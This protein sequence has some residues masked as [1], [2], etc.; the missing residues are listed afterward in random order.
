M[1]LS[2]SYRERL[3][4]ED[5]LTIYGMSG[6]EL[7]IRIIFED[8]GKMMERKQASKDSLSSSYWAGEAIAYWQA[9]TQL[10][11]ASLLERL[12]LTEIK[13]MYSPYHEMDFGAFATEANRRYKENETIT[14]LQMARSKAKLS[15][16]KLANR[17]GL[18]LR[19]LQDYEQNRKSLSNAAAK[20]I[21]LLAKALKVSPESLLD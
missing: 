7:A 2:S 13:S 6:Q 11:F 8:S 3:E 19:T 21:F 20:T 18:S 9:A 17:S 14:P 16:S 10:S 12:S 15:Q 5:L 1:F 4:Q